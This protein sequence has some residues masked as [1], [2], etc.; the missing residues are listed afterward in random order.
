MI[1]DF[2]FAVILFVYVLPPELK[3]GKRLS[4]NFLPFNSIFSLANRIPNTV[5]SR[6]KDTPL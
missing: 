1:K 3:V 5:N 2:V 6:L 4:C